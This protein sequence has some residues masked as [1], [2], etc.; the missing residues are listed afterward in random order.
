MRYGKDIT[1]TQGPLHNPSFHGFSDGQ[2]SSISARTPLHPERIAARLIRP[3]EFDFSDVAP[4]QAQSKHRLPEVKMISSFIL[5]RQF[6]RELSPFTFGKLLRETLI[7]LYVE[8]PPMQLLT[9]LLLNP[10]ECII[11]GSVPGD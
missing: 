10:P 2:Y 3:L 7:G 8:S 4:N 9:C 6:Y 11:S 1:S 5:R